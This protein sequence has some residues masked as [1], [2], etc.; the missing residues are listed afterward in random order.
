MYVYTNYSEPNGFADMF[1]RLD[2]LEGKRGNDEYDFDALPSLAGDGRLSPATAPTR[3]RLPSP[4]AATT[5]DDHHHPY[6]HPC[7][8]D[9]SDSDSDGNRSDCDDKT[10]TDKG[11]SR[12]GMK[13]IPHSPWTKGST[14]KKPRLESSVQ[15]NEIAVQHIKKVLAITPPIKINDWDALSRAFN[16]HNPDIK[17]T[18]P[19]RAM[20]SPGCPLGVALLV[21][22][23]ISSMGT[24]SGDKAIL[25]LLYCGNMLRKACLAGGGGRKPQTNAAVKKSL[26]YVNMSGLKGIPVRLSYDHLPKTTTS[27]KMLEDILLNI[28]SNTWYFY[29]GYMHIQFE[30]GSLTVEW[31]VAVGTERVVCA[32]ATMSSPHGNSVVTVDICPPTLPAR[33]GCF[34]LNCKYPQ[35]RKQSPVN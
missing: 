25:P 31:P 6:K 1:D 33:P 17:D 23:M 14:A 22:F 7:D 35:N 28:V 11:P 2:Q 9:G 24:L 20:A 12:T 18:P 26:S 30:P 34:V 21:M 16:D 19:N 13:P 8:S 10:Y 5:P 4:P 29:L 15:H 32:K 3:R 27:K